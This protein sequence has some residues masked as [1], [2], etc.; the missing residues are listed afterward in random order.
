MPDVDACGVCEWRT[1]IRQMNMAYSHLSCPAIVTRCRLFQVGICSLH[2]GTIVRWHHSVLGTRSM[3]MKQERV[4]S[5]ESHPPKDVLRHTSV[6]KTAHTVKKRAVR[7]H[8][9]DC[10]LACPNASCPSRRAPEANCLQMNMQKPSESRWLVLGDGDFSYSRAL[11]RTGFGDNVVAT[12][13]DSRD[14]LVEKYA[15]V[16]LRVGVILDQF[17]LFV[18]VQRAGGQTFESVNLLDAYSMQ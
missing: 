13:L 16:R 1:Q 18:F 15:S 4:C 7:A 3:A 14:T 10:P 2:G 8:V 5:K 9:Q 17:S 12:S 6:C 11:A